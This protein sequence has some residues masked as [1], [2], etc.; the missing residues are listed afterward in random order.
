MSQHGMNRR[1]VRHT[2]DDHAKNGIVSRYFQSL[3][4]RQPLPI[5][6]TVIVGAIVIALIA[7]GIFNAMVYLE[8]MREA[9]A[10][11]EIATPSTKA[12][13]SNN[14]G[15]D[16]PNAAKDPNAGLGYNINW[17]EY[18]DVNPEIY[19]WLYVPGT[20]IN[21]P[22]AQHAGQDDVY[23]LKH[24]Y[25]GEPSALGAAFSE[26]RNSQDFSD[27]VTVIYGHDAYSVFKNLH[28][29]EDTNF[30]NEHDKFYVYTPNNRMYTYRIVAAY[31]T[32][33][34]HIL[35]TND[36]TSESGRQQYYDK[37][38]HPTDSIQQIRKGTTL[39]AGEKILQLST[40]MLNELP[41]ANPHRYI[42]T[43]V[44]ESE[45]DAAAQQ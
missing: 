19:A 3:K 36:T 25:R 42:V 31:R 41:G 44:L 32:D 14:T 17:G 27:P 34:S 10:M 8:D 2:D 13:R 30:F 7:W 9:K 6:I 38:M 5:A 1:H 29:F 22:V 33:N 43:G 35:N 18:R 15:D 21:L 40:C 20:G 45:Q 23:Y 28:D 26:M 12:Q 24:N 37:V 16:D 39:Q 11:S 4:N